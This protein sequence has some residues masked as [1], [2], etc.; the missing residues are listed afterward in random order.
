MAPRGGHLVTSLLVGAKACC[1]RAG[2]TAD[3]RQPHTLLAEFL[4]NLAWAWIRHLLRR[5]FFETQSGVPT[6]YKPRGANVPA[7][8]AQLI[9]ALT[10]IPYSMGAHAYDVFR[11]G[12]DWFLTQKLPGLLVG[13]YVE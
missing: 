4:G 12:G 9:K 2:W 10:G 11:H 3:G 7:T 6:L 5:I 1:L 8:A 13:Y